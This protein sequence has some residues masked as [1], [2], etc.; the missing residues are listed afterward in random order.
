VFHYIEPNIVP[1]S[2][3]EVIPT[4]PPTKLKRLN[5]SHTPSSSNTKS[6]IG[7]LFSRLLQED[8]KIAY[9]IFNCLMNMKKCT[10]Q[11][12]RCGF[13]G[14]VLHLGIKILK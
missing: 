12:I 14:K 3:I 6:S 13:T 8:N 2:P 1:D 11:L 5:M 4:A 7:Q 9:D 10:K